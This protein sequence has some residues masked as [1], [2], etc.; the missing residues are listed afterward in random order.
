[1][2]N[3]PKPTYPKSPSPVVG[4]RLVVAQKARVVVVQAA[5]AAAGCLVRPKPVPVEPPAVVDEGAPTNHRAAA[6]AADR[7]TADEVWVRPC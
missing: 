6:E 7:A 1:M 2:P 4:E 5:A 3:G